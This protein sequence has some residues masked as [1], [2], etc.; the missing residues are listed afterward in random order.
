MDIGLPDTVTQM[1]RQIAALGDST[2]CSARL[3]S[4]NSVLMF[5]SGHDDHTHQAGRA[6]A[7]AGKGH[8]FT[9]QP[10]KIKVEIFRG[11]W[12]RRARWVNRVWLRLSNCT[13]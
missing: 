8:Q 11:S 9:Q 4:G 6:G 2:V 1:Q 12:D 3:T 7:T 5:W 10:G 13:S